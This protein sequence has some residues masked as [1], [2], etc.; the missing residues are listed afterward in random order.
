MPGID[1]ADLGGHC[2]QYYRPEFR[3]KV[4]AGCTVM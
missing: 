1:N 2:F 4:A 3:E